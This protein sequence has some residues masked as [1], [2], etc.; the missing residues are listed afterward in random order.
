MTA[1]ETSTRQTAGGHG[2]AALGTQV[3][4]E[5]SIGTARM[6]SFAGLG[7]A[8]SQTDVYTQEGAQP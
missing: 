3:G 6:C 8:K 1:A 7:M 2:F 5:L 4:K